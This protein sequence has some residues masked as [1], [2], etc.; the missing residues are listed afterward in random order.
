MA[1]KG[2][3]DQRA[4]LARRAAEVAVLY[5]QAKHPRVVLPAIPERTR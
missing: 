1:G 2:Y 5:G 4:C 3:I